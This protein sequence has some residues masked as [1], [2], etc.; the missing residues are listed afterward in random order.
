MAFKDFVNEITTPY[1]DNGHG[2][3]VAGISSSNGILS[4]GLFSGIAPQ[5]N[6]KP[7]MAPLFGHLKPLNGFI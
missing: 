4:D 1:D 7:A 2:T 6:M 3:H 5:S